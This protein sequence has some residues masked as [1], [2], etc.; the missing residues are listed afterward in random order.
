M[1]ILTFP[2]PRLREISLPVQEIGEDIRSL[3]RNNMIPALFSQGAAG[4][5]APQV[6]HLLRIFLLDGRLL[7]GGSDLSPAVVCIN[8]EIKPW[9]ARVSREEGCLS[10]PGAFAKITRTRGVHMRALDLDGNPFEITNYEL[11]ARVILHEMDHLDGK[12]MCDH[13]KGTK[14]DRFLDKV[15]L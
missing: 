11:A 5:A 4:I 8:P 12:L 7:P 13:L 15:K 1:A 14:R 10:F 9:G 3:V 6:G 2:D